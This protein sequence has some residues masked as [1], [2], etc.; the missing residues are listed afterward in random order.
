MEIS[1]PAMVS[2]GMVEEPV[3]ADRQET[4]LQP[5]QHLGQEQQELG[6]EQLQFAETFFG[7]GALGVTLRRRPEDGRVFIYDIVPNSQAV[8]LDVLPNDELW[9]VGESEIGDLPLDKEAWT[10]LITFIKQSPRP[11]RFIWRRRCTA[12]VT[13]LSQTM[14]AA[15]PVEVAPVAVAPLMSPE[16]AELEKLVARFSSRDKDTHKKFFMLDPAQILQSGRRIVRQGDLFVD[17]KSPGSGGSGQGLS[18][19]SSRSSTLRRVILCNDLLLVACPLNGNVFSLEY[20]LQ[21]STCKLRSL[22]HVFGG[23]ADP[24]D[25]AASN[26]HDHNNNY[27]NNNNNNNN[28]FRLVFD[29]LFPGGELQFSV[30]DNDVAA[31]EVWVLSLYLTMCDTVE[32]SAKVLGWRHQYMLGTMHS[33]VMRC[34][35]ERIRELIALCQSG[36]L[37]FSSI[38][39][40]D[41]DGYTPLHYACMLRLRNV[42]K[43]L[44]EATADVT[45]T[46]RH[47]LT[48]LHWAAL[49]L[50]DY[51]LALLCTHVFDLDLLDNWG[52]TPLVV[53]CIEGRDLSGKSDSVLLKNCLQSML[54][55][56]PNLHYVDSKGQTLL[57]YLA[58]SWQC[59]GL[60]LLL[61]AGCA[62]VNSTDNRYFMT[63]LHYAARSVP[64]K[65]A[66]GDGMRIV[67]GI[68][69]AGLSERI[70]DANKDVEFEAINESHG[71]DTLRCLF[72]YGARPNGKD[73]QGRT[74]LMIVLESD[75]HSAWVAAND[76]EAAI[77]VLLSH[78][79]RLDDATNPVPP[80][81]TSISTL[82]RNRFPDLNSAALMEKWNLLP[83]LDCD[84]LEIRL[85]VVLLFHFVSSII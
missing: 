74:P 9:A 81:G 64:I 68:S 69:S 45:A 12:A 11:L 27:Y 33:A 34:D 73:V 36:S 16:R 19:F 53:A 35:E 30:T 47:G 85:V 60:E 63:P 2:T 22:G 43:I 79:A 24:A 66:M 17:C 57:H 26:S 13:S 10:G 18:L 48:P 62:D 61:E 14:S 59:D 37:E 80:G 84:K 49:Q 71:V 5:Q 23:L 51:S 58:A 75:D 42:V 83:G 46:D 7:E 76:T 32:D 28:P 56:K 54:T 72:K 44:H 8:N 3:P 21:L 31:K 50:D 41:E 70:D 15:A 77:S 25:P 52:R 65:R 39:S 20:I 40:V 1:D 6:Q 82:L 78:G 67:N 4:D 38:E 29:I 55:H